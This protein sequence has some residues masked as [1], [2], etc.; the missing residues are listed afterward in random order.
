MA[1]GQEYRGAP[2]VNGVKVDDVDDVR[3]CTVG[4]E[5]VR[6]LENL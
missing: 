6:A 4:L 5:N 2:D 1:A 3:R